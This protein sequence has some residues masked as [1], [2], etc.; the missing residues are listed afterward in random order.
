MSLG[1]EKVRTGREG[2]SEKKN[3]I[4]TF[5]PGPSKGAKWMGKGAIKQPLTN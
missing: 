5:I 3:N 1:A 2:E 4:N